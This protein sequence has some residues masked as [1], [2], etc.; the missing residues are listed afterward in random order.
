ML[1]KPDNHSIKGKIKFPKSK[2]AT[3]ILTF[4]DWSKT[5]AGENTKNF[6]KERLNKYDALVFLGDQGYD[7]HNH[8]GKVGNEYLEFVK[9]ITSEVPFQVR[10]LISK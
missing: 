10:I 1:I 4:G 9:P 8:A 2:E 5:K 7:L 6:I 3:N